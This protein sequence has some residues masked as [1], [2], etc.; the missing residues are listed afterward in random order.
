MKSSVVKIDLEKSWDF[1]IAL[2]TNKD[3][4]GRT[5]KI[6]LRP[7]TEKPR[8]NRRMVAGPVT[9]ASFNCWKVTEPINKLPKLRAFF[10]VCKIIGVGGAAA[11]SVGGFGCAI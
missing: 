9:G 8:K 4:P 3:C 6:W 5:K 11:S 7:F 2:S 1:F 10:F